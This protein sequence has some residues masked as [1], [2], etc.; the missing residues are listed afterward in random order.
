MTEK[1]SKAFFEKMDAGLSQKNTPEPESG[2]SKQPK[3]HAQYSREQMPYRDC[4]GIAVFNKDGKVWA[5]HRLVEEND[6]NFGSSQLWQ[7]PQ[8]GIDKGEAP[9]AAAKRELYEETGMTS[10]EL[11]DEVADWLY[12]DLPDHVLGRALKGKYRGQRQ[13]W[14]AFRFVGDEREIIINEPLG[15]QK[16]EFDEWSWVDL[17]QLPALVVPFKRE[18]YERLVEQFSPLCLGFN[19][20]GA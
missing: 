4:V 9:L 1:D 17:I 3:N 7:L 15:G 18:V 2:A 8:G 5:G 16:P 14:F 6:E 11:L 13:R 12:Y 10:V 20:D 19:S